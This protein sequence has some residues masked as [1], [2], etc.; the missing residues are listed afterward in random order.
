MSTFN[1]LWGFK[2]L[3]L[4]HD[5]ANNEIHWRKGVLQQGS[6][7]R[8]SLWWERFLAETSRRVLLGVLRI[9]LLPFNAQLKVIT[10]VQRV[11]PYEEDEG[12]S[13]RDIAQ[14]YVLCLRRFP[15]EMLP[16]LAEITVRRYPLSPRFQKFVISFIGDGEDKIRERHQRLMARTFFSE[17]LVLWV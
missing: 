1:F 15:D 10:L 7:Y 8:K 2:I 4:P 12:G 6:Q 3:V 13:R 11:W 17:R 9:D 14:A 5:N 16:R